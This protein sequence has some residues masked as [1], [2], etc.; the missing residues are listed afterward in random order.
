MASASFSVIASDDRPIQGA[1]TVNYAAVSSAAQTAN[2]ND[3]SFFLTLHLH[4][5]LARRIFG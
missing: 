5:R 3:C 1:I 4:F 2:S